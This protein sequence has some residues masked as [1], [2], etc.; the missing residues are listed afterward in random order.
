MSWPGSKRDALAWGCLA[1]GGR[2]SHGMICDSTMLGW[3]GGGAGAA[4]LLPETF[5]PGDTPPVSRPRM[6]GK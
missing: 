6:D 5:A 1:S 3:V 2:A 4:A